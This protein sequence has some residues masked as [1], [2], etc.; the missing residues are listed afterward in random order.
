MKWVVSLKLRPLHPRCPLNRRLLRPHTFHRCADTLPTLSPLRWHFPAAKVCWHGI[1]WAE[2]DVCLLWC[3]SQELTTFNTRFTDLLLRKYSPDVKQNCTL[4][5][6][7][8]WSETIIFTRSIIYKTNH[9]TN[10]ETK[11][12]QQ[13]R[14]Y[15]YKKLRLFN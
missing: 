6:A 13:W 1:V 2:E 9:F 3:T 11:Q 8:Y 15:T 4:T 7:I 5:I 10:N 12:N 14:F